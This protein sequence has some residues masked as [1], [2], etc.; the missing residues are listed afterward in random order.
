MKNVI[1]LLALAALFTLT[2]CS[3]KEVEITRE[4]EV[5]RVVKETIIEKETIVETVVASSGQDFDAEAEKVT[6]DTICE[7]I[8]EFYVHGDEEKI[9]KY[10]HEDWKGVFLVPGC[11]GEFNR[12]QWLGVWG[13]TGVNTEDHEWQIG[14]DLAVRTSRQTWKCNNTACCGKG[15]YYNTEVFRKEDGQWLMVHSLISYQ[16]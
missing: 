4:V 13:S 2:A 8:T 6:L 10:Y 11:S 9:S 16:R 14:R 1:A 12:K 3:T 5:T 15:D 7:E